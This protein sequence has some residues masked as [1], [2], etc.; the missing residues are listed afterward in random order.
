MTAR[1]KLPQR[2]FGDF[3]RLWTARQAQPQL[4]GIVPDRVPVRLNRFPYEGSLRIGDRIECNARSG[5]FRPCP[6]GGSRFT[7]ESGA[8]PHVARLRCDGCGNGAR[9]LSRCFME[10]A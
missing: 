6:C 1:E 3:Q 4:H 7:I 5:V 10:M 8:G 9:W 2:I